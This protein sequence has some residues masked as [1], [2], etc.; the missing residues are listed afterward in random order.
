MDTQNIKAKY[1]AAMARISGIHGEPG[2]PE[3]AKSVLDL[4]SIV[5]VSPGAKA[6][7]AVLA[8]LGA[9]LP[10]D[11]YAASELFLEAAQSGLPP[12]VRELGALVLMNGGPEGLGGMLLKQAARG[13]D[14]IA[15]FLITR[16]A[17][18]G[19]YFW[20]YQNL[21]NLAASLSASVPFADDIKQAVA[22]LDMGLTP[23]VD[24]G[25]D[26]AACQRAANIEPVE[27]AN[28][29]LLHLS[30][31]QI[32]AYSAVLSPLECDYL[33]AM[34]T[35]L[36]QP[37]KVVDGDVSAAKEK[38]Y[39]TSDGAVFLPHKLDRPLLKILKAISVASN[40]KPEHGE[41][42]S[43]LRYRP[44]QEYY[45]HHDFLEEDAAD[46]SKIK[47]CGQR[48]ATTL[49]YL[50]D[51]YEG[52]ATNF[53]KLNIS[54]K[55]SAGSSLYFTNADEDGTPI[56]NSLHAGR[57]ITGGEKW[58]ATLWIREKPFWPWAV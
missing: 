10:Q 50:N 35:P 18:R 13:G 19:R 1:R 46:Y 25:F 36:M 14:W 12:L 15:G 58:L 5:D 49:T 30:G 56:P 41:F 24:E 29:K 6:K 23:I 48:C 11:S 8:E 42:L 32:K 51:D 37:S 7:L 33:I 16:E 28:S 47:A 3:F 38:G 55:P 4:R 52:G 22:G 2:P 53:P 34:A 31:P 9:G 20:D 21:Q 44:G 45:P 26:L 54:H 43:V 39:R 57:V 27:P 17:L 40:I